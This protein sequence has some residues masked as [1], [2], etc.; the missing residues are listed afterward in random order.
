MIEISEKTKKD[1]L[2]ILVSNAILFH[3]FIADSFTSLHDPDFFDLLLVVACGAT[4][5]IAKITGWSF[6]AEGP[7]C[8]KGNGKAGGGGRWERAFP[9]KVTEGPLGSDNGPQACLWL[10]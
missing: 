4:I 5:I 10:S 6:E 3:S 1:D 9:Q 8:E 7:V 2:R